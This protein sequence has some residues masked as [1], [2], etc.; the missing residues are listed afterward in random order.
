MNM[1]DFSFPPMA[2]GFFDPAQWLRRSPADANM[3]SKEASSLF[4]FIQELD[5]NARNNHWPPMSMSDP[6]QAHTAPTSA[7]GSDAVRLRRILVFALP[8]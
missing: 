7:S 5:N 4:Q 1:A 8:V 3:P 2:N 6:V